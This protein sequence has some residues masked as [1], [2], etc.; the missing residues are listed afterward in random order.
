MVV[1]TMVED[2]AETAGAPYAGWISFGEKSVDDVRASMHAGEVSKREALNDDDDSVGSGDARFSEALWNKAKRRHAARA[3]LDEK[4]KL[5]EMEALSA[6][7]N[8]RE[9]RTAEEKAKMDAEEAMRQERQNREEEDRARKQREAVEAARQAALREVEA[10][11][12]K[13]DEWD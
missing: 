9:K 4:L 12:D 1:E 8:E 2:V 6:R 13:Q 3:A 7:A 11:E 10:M 5:Q